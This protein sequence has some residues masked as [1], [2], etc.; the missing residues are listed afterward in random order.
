MTR[1]K[2]LGG[3][4]AKRSGPI[5]GLNRLLIRAHGGLSGIS[6]DLIQTIHNKKII[7]IMFGN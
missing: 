5:V 3:P 4:T 2:Q 7:L 1:Q 6:G